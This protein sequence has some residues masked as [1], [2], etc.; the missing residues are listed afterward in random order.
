MDWSNREDGTG[1]NSPGRQLGPKGHVTGV[2]N[3][4][5]LSGHA[6]RGPDRISW[7]A[8]LFAASPPA[9]RSTREVQEIEDI[10]NRLYSRPTQSAECSPRGRLYSGEGSPVG[11]ALGEGSSP[12][13]GHGTRIGWV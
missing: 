11:G 10:V 4:K 6:V 12:I 1:L 7:L 5:F 2:S 3:R 13:G 8:S 9:Q